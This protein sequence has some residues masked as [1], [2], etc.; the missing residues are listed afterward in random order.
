[1]LNNFSVCSGLFAKCWLNEDSFRG[2]Q[3]QGAHLDNI[4]GRS[5]F[6]LCETSIINVFGSG[7]SMSFNS[8][9][10]AAALICSGI[11][12]IKT[13]LPPSAAV[14]LSFC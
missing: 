3:D 11:Q 13:L 6:F 4:V 7:S 9:F 12:I 1:M 10:D 5:L 14:K 2:L 8:L